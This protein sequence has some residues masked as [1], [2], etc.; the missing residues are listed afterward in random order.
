M[1]LISWWPCLVSFGLESVGNSENYYSIQIQFQYVFYLKSYAGHIYHKSILLWSSVSG[2]QPKR[3]S[4][5]SD[6]P[7]TE[8]TCPIIFMKNYNRYIL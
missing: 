4:H 7:K 1:K 3:F 6:E 2:C 8:Y 5:S